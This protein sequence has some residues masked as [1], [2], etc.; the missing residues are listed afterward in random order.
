MFHRPRFLEK[1]ALIVVTT[2]SSGLKD[3]TDYL[4]GVAHWFGFNVIGSLGVIATAFAHAPKYKAGI[5]QRIEALSTELLDA[6]K[7]RKRPDPTIYD[8]IVFGVFKEKAAYIERDKEFWQ[9][10]G[11]FDKEY[12]LD[13]PIHPFRRFIANLQIKK[14]KKEK[15]KSIK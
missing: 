8:L 9:A 14:M 13:L 3:V 6:M 5:M 4:N 11:W 15:A 12:Y 1:A 2:A 10:K 7:T